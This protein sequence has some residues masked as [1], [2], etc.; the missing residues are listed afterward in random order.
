MPGH[1][2]PNVAQS[3]DSELAHQYLAFIRGVRDPDDCLQV[4][5]FD[6]S[7]IFPEASPSPTEVLHDTLIRLRD[8]ASEDELWTVECAKLATIPPLMRSVIMSQTIAPRE[9]PAIVNDAV[10]TGQDINKALFNSRTSKTLRR[11]LDEITGAVDTTTR[12]KAEEVRRNLP[13][14]ILKKILHPVQSA[15]NFV[16]DMTS[17]VGG[18]DR[19]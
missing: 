18:M 4:E 16:N 8:H 11:D 2:L 5:I 13:S 17:A 1:E 10:V 7:K 15:Q 12:Q 9:I 6:D 19:Y 3:F 14:S